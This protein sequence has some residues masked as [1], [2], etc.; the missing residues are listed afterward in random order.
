MTTEGAADPADVVSAAFRAEYGRAVATLT[1]LLGDI[2]SAEEAVQEAFTVAAQRWPADGTPPNPGGWIVTTARNRALDRI[3]REST[4]KHRY[5]QAY[6]ITDHDPEPEEVGP[7]AD[8]RLRLVFTCCHPAL[9]PSAQVALTLRLLGGLTTSEIARAFMVPEPTM[10][11]RIS[12]AKNKIRT[13]GIPYRVP[14][15]ADLPN[16]LT[17]VLAVVYL[18]FNEGYTATGGTSL[19][20]DDLCAEAIRLARMLVDLMPDEPEARGLLALLLL[21]AARRPARVA[22]DGRLVTLANQDRR[23][24]DRELIAE[25]QN[26]V[27]QCLRRN[28]PG[29]YQWQ[30]AIAAVHSDATEAS[31]T[32]WAQIRALYDQLLAATASPVVA[33][34]RAVAVMETDGPG[35]ALHVLDGLM[36]SPAAAQLE[37][38]QHFHATRAEALAR[39]RRVDEAL[40]AY[41]RA[42]ALTGND[43]ERDFLRSQRAQLDPR[44]SNSADPPGASN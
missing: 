40:D 21:T 41:D 42:C 8:D 44:W 25:G 1:R 18:I 16:R 9:A 15:D 19:V 43:A 28:A 30:A 29:P 14:Q 26:L 6:R 38:Y 23:L 12:R 2:D 35:A 13:A 4:R 17:P 33:V 7:V 37:S 3:R 22:P 36:N 5:E 32:E 39:L 10:G 20:R 24:W 31:H 27:R 34:N 11:Q